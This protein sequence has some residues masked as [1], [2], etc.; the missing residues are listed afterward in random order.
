MSHIE[1]QRQAQLSPSDR[2]RLY[3]LMARHYLEVNYEA[4]SR[5]L[6][7]KEAVLLVRGP[8]GEIEGF[9]T[10]GRFTCVVNGIDHD[11][12]YTGDTMLSPDLWAKSTWLRAWSKY[13]WD[14][15]RESSVASVYFLLCT[16]NHRTYRVLPALFRRFSPE[17]NQEPDADDKARLDAFGAA[18]FGMEFD[19][20]RGVVELHSSLCV[21]DD[22]VAAVSAGMEDT[23]G[24]FFSARNP[25]F[26]KSDYL[27]CMARLTPSNLTKL[28]QRIF[29]VQGSRVQV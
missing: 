28:A 20:A 13:I 27:V 22:L 10:L 9:S 15:S 17:P 29:G 5:D 14:C 24:Q 7:G 18:K 6:A 23:L 19:S 25:G 26:L 4:F 12:L 16:A 11:V 2:D 3:E 1:V 8:A 21:R